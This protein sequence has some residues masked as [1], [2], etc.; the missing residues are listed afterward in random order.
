MIWWLSFAD[1]DKPA[2]QQFL[3][4]C[5]VEAPAFVLAAFV[6]R[7]RGCNPGGECRGFEIP[8][9]LAREHGLGPEVMDRLFSKAELDDLFGPLV[10]P[11]TGEGVP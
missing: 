10:N 8:P 5:L 4:A 3:G 7:A 9:D 11:D 2:G 1:P 6:A